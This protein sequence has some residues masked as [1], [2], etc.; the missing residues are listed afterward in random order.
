MNWSS[1]N[2]TLIG[3]PLAGSAA[4][5]LSMPKA[6]ECRST[7][8]T[9]L[10]TP[11]RST[12]S[13]MARADSRS[14][15]NGFSQKTGSPRAAAASTRRG[16][17]AVHVHTYTASQPSSTSSSDVHT[18]AP[19]ARAKSAARAASGSNTPAQVASAP[20]TCNDFE[21]Y[22]AMRPAPRNP[23]LTVIADLLVAFFQRVERRRLD[24]RAANRRVVVREAQHL[25]G[26]RRCPRRQVDVD[27]VLHRVFEAETGVVARVAFE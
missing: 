6:G 27:A 13:F 9:W 1:R 14:I 2:T 18:V 20:D 22:V 17:S 11:A 23:T 5:A 19:L 21:W 12:E 25:R 26:L 4:I 24:D 16:C 15:A 7:S 3:R 10:T 8:P